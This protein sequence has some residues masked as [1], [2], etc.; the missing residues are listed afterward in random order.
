MGHNANPTLLDMPPE[1]ILLIG[2]MEDMQAA[3]IT[4]MRATYVLLHP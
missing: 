3:D 1:I 2:E 4:N